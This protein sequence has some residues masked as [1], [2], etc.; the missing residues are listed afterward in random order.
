[1]T[2]EPKFITVDEAAKILG[3]STSAVMSLI[4][5]DELASVIV[6]GQGFCVFDRSVYDYQERQA[7]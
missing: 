4:Y 5:R 7:E 6:E 3:I 1:M 2:E